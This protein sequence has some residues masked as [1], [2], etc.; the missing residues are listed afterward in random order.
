MAGALERRDP[1]PLRAIAALA[2]EAGVRYLDVNLGSGRL[3]N[4]GSLRFV[5]EEL[6]GC[7]NGGLLI[8]TPRASVMEAAVENWDG[9]LV[10]NGYSGD[11]DRAPVLDVARASGADLVVFLMAGGIPKRCDERL[12]LAAELFGRCAEAGIA[13]DRLWIDPVVAP[14]GWMEGQEYDVAL[15]E[16]LRRLPEV[17]GEPVKTVVGLSN[18]TTGASGAKR[19][20]WLQEVFLSM[21]A[22]AGLTHAMVDVRN[23]RLLQVARAL[24]ALAGERLFAPDEFAEIV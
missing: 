3:G 24:E 17:F 16:I 13:L 6:R 4:V 1:E 21:A 20:P 15:I 14:L 11:P 22:G 5:L 7:W 12:A 2:K 8:D 10:L 23:R 9:F 18:L 19:V